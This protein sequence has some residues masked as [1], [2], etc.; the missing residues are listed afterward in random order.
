M[1]SARDGGVRP[2]NMV[3]G[4]SRSGTM[5]RNLNQAVVGANE[6]M[7]SVSRKFTTAPRA[8]ASAPGATRLARGAR[9]GGGRAG[10]REPEEKNRHGE[11]DEE[12]DQHAGVS[13]NA[14]DRARNLVPQ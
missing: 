2:Q 11:N 3:C 4:I 5:R 14:Q 8:R 7:P 6:P 9:A 13:L 12:R 10:E 1:L